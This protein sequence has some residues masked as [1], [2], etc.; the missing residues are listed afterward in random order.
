MRY[1]SK[2]IKSANVS[3]GKNTNLD[4]PVIVKTSDIMEKLEKDIAEKHKIEQKKEEKETIKSQ[5][6][7]RKKLFTYEDIVKLDDKSI[8][9]VL[10]DIDNNVLA[11]AIKASQ[12]NIQD[13]LFKN[14]SNRVAEMIKEEIEIM[15]PVRV[16]DVEMAQDT[17][18]MKIRDLE[19]TGEVVIN[20]GGEDEVF[21]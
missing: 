1:L 8:Q 12:K 7:I 16:K 3:L 13:L 21:V 6:E 14:L 19:K 11:L 2:V 9:R 17:I 5:E 20:R 15:G 18:V 4:N 10:K